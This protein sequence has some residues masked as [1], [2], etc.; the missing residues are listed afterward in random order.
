MLNLSQTIS[1]LP[2]LQNPS[3]QH[4]SNLPLDAYKP[5][6]NSDI[7]DFESGNRLRIIISALSSAFSSQVTCW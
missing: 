7:G 4:T 5:N 6:S 3:G 2:F 1:T